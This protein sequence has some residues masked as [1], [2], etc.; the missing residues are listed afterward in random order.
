MT[1]VNRKPVGQ[2]E[3]DEETEERSGEVPQPD[4]FRAQESMT[5]GARTAVPRSQTSTKGQSEG[6]EI[7]IWQLGVEPCGSGR[8]PD[9]A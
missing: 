6:H 2:D 4:H 7:G 8:S 1:L 9:D 5:D 3:G